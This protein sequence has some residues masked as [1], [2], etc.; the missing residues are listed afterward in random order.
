MDHYIN[1]KRGDVA[2]VPAPPKRS[3]QHPVAARPGPSRRSHREVSREQLVQ[4]SH[5][6]DSQHMEINRA[7]PD[8]PNVQYIDPA[9]RGP[10][11]RSRREAPS[12]TRPDKQNRSASRTT[13]V[14]SHSSQDD[15][16]YRDA[17]VYHDNSSCKHDVNNEGKNPPQPKLRVVLVLKTKPNEKKRYV[18]PQGLSW[19][20]FLRGV[21]ER[22]RTVHV[23]AIYDA[24]NVQI[25]EVGDIIDGETLFVVPYTKKEHDMNRIEKRKKSGPTGITTYFNNLEQNDTIEGGV[26]LVKP[27]TPTEKKKEYVDKLRE[28]EK[29][30]EEQAKQRQAVGVTTALHK[31]E[32]EGDRKQGRKFIPC[33]RPTPKRPSNVAFPVETM[34]Y[35]RW[36]NLDPKKLPD[37]RKPQGPKMVENKGVWQL[38]DKGQGNM[39]AGFD[40][41]W[42]KGKQFRR[43]RFDSGRG[44]NETIMGRL[45]NYSPRNHLWG[46]CYKSSHLMDTQFFNRKSF[47]DRQKDVNTQQQ[48]GKKEDE[49][50]RGDMPSRKELQGLRSK[51]KDRRT[52]HTPRYVDRQQHEKRASHEK[53]F[54]R[55]KRLGGNILV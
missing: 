43:R 39:P 24:S 38:S 45:L 2:R 19:E 48:Q 18:I 26:K 33:P 28:K 49:I 46:R 52:T 14:E 44:A 10:I 40:P 50:R 21:C 31:K 7:Y 37:Q 22:L 1:G 23:K 32:Y 9:R 5:A 41:E 3:V 51:N 42:Q 55:K 13:S 12:E 34:S 53:L 17:M 20:T 4:E 30:L 36:K 47:L 35:V 11:R 27:I 16:K 8:E 54:I 15:D 29:K 6:K 25:C